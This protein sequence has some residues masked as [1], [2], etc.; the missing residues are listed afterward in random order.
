MGQQTTYLPNF[1]ASYPILAPA[2]KPG[3]V[4][5]LAATAKFAGGSLTFTANPVAASTATY[6]GTVV[7][8]V[9]SG[10]VGNQVNIGANLAAT[11]QNLQAFMAASSDVQIVKFK[12]SVSATVQTLSA[13]ALGTGGNALTIATTVVGAT[14]SGATLTGGAA[15]ATTPNKPQWGSTAGS[16]PPTL[17]VAKSPP[18]ATASTAARASNAKKH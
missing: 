1:L 4:T 5:V 13:A 17:L 16:G 18:T 12:S 6:N 10:A 14:A 7:T 3:G 15:G 9:A 2:Q 8:F 11:L